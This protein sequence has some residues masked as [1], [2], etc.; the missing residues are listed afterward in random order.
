MSTWSGQ[1]LEAMLLSSHRYGDGV[2]WGYTAAGVT[3]DGA[4]PR[5]YD[6]TVVTD[7][8]FVLGA[9]LR[10]TAT[11]EDVPVELLTAAVCLIAE[12][13]GATAAANYVNYMPDF[14]SDSETPERVYAGCTGLR[15]DRVIAVRGPTTILDYLADP[16]TAIITAARHMLARI[17]Q[18]QF[19][20]PM[21]AAAYNTDGILLDAA[22]RWRMA[23][24]QQIDRFVGWFNTIVGMAQFDPSV[25][26]SA[27]SFTAVLATIPGPQPPAPAATPTQRYRLPES[28][29][30]EDAGLMTICPRNPM[31]NTI[32]A[33]DPVTVSQIK[34]VANDASNPVIGLPNGLP[35]FNYPDRGGTFRQLTSDEVISLYMAMR[36]YINAINYYDAG[37]VPSLPGLPVELP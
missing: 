17:D 9:D 6:A 21:M 32:W 4:S 31:L 24:G 10:Q 1:Q 25:V 18:T 33:L 5:T 22:S 16:I 30:H 15:L 11:E 28:Q 14:V 20:P 35:V 26:G 34:G 37:R 12:S 29:A 19:Q 13:I 23:P 27:P 8:L 7:V 3:E 2:A 36:D